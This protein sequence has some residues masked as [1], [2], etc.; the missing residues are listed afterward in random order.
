[1]SATATL[2]RRPAVPDPGRSLALAPPM[3]L[4]A[5]RGALVA[6][7]FG[8]SLFAVGGS[9]QLVVAFGGSVSTLG[10]AASYWDGAGAL[11]GWLVV[12]VAACL[13]YRAA[14]DLDAGRTTRVGVAVAGMGAV[15][16]AT[17]QACVVWA[18]AVQLDSGRG[19]G[20]D[21]SHAFAST[22]TREVLELSRARWAFVAA[23]W[24]VLAAAAFVARPRR[25]DP[26]A[27]P[28]GAT[29]TNAPWRRALVALS[30]AA[31]LA[32]VG[33]AVQFAL[34]V[35]GRAKATG[36]LDVAL[37]YV[38]PVG[39]WLVAAIGLWLVGAA[40]RAG[41]GTRSLAVGW[42]LGVLGAICLATSAATVAAWQEL[43]L[44]DVGA[45]W[46]T[47]LARVGAATSWAGWVALALLV[48]LAA[49]RLH[50]GAVS[51]AVSP[52]ALST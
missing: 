25:P 32:A 37:V 30:V 2:T 17:A 3:R 11:A 52:R 10:T 40:L 13:A 23:G 8:L 50:E 29:A 14:M 18:I 1:M 21:L 36:G 19:A 38:P 35:D 39:A 43:L 5:L 7:T 46:S 4:A 24:I 26:A 27:A 9:R 45:S 20:G 22:T 15:L 33:P 44:H 16:L 51:R 48:G 31:L 6:L 49:T 12:I 28:P 41:S 42:P 47:T 34:L